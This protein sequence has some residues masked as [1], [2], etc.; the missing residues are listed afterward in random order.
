MRHNLS[1]SRNG[2]QTCTADRWCAA[3]AGGYC[4][5]AHR[6]DTGS[7][8]QSKRAMSNLKAETLARWSLEGKTAIVT[9][10]TKVGFSGGGQPIWQ[11]IGL[12]RG[13]LRD[14]CCATHQQLDIWMGT[15]EILD[16]GADVGC[17]SRSCQRES[18]LSRILKGV[19]STW[20]ST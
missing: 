18:T 9:G 5:R 19:A 16:V 10:G 14:C 20:W 15:T 8:S 6:K 1:E 13:V 2:T 17:G 3:W 11:F 12:W 4:S 7:A